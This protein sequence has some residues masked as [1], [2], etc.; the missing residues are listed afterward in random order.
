MLLETENKTFHTTN[1]LLNKQKKTKKTRVRIEQ[2]FNISKTNV[3]QFLK[4]K[5]RIEKTNMSK[6]DNHTKKIISHVQH[7][8]KCNQLGHN[9]QICELKSVISKK[10]MI[11]NI[12]NYH[13]N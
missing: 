11:Y 7:C 3:L 9:A 4:N 1:E 10:K 5:I 13:T 2:S 12:T 8:G 6:N